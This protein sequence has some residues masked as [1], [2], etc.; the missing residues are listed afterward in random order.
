MDDVAIAT[1]KKSYRYLGVWINLSLDWSDMQEH[2]LNHI[3]VPLNIIRSKFY[4]SPS[5]VVKL[6]NATVM[7]IVGY[8]MQVIF[9]DAQWIDKINN[10]ICS[11]LNSRIKIYTSAT[12][13]A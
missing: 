3:R 7:A 8:R 13:W 2:L 10:I 5:L 6:I 9:F 12:T 11:V 1:D 4:I